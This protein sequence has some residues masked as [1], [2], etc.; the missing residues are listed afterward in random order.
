MQ[1]KLIHIILITLLVAS[2][3][4]S[5]PTVS[6]PAALYII[7]TNDIHTNID[8]AITYDQIAAL[9]KSLGSTGANVL[10]LDNGDY[11]QGTP[12]GSIDKGE[13]IIGIMEKCG[14]DAAGIGN[15]ETDFG[16]DI[17]KQRISD[18]SFPILSCNFWKLDSSGNKSELLGKPYQIFKFEDYSV[19]VVGISTPETIASGQKRYFFDENDKP[20]YSFSGDADGSEFYENIQE[21][22][23]AARSEGADYVIA[24]GHLGVA[25]ASAPWRSYDVIRNTNGIDAF[26]D[27]HSHSLVCETVS[28]K[29]GKQIPLS[30]TGCYLSHLGLIS[31]NSEGEFSAEI[32]DELSDSDASTKALCSQLI[33]KVDEAFGEVIAESEINF[34]IDDENGNRLVRKMTTNASRLSTDAFYYYVCEVSQIPADIAIYNSGGVRNNVDAGKW[35]Y[36]SCQNIL[37]F[38]NLLCVIS[39]SGQTIKDALEWGAQVCPDE[40]AGPLVQCAMMSYEV[41]TSI[42]STVQKDEYDQWAGAPTGE[43]RVRNIKIFNT[44]SGEYENLDPDKIYKV[45][46]VD[47]I[48]LNSGSG[49]TMWDK[50]PNFEV[51]LTDV[52]I[53]NM[54]LAEY[55]KAFED[56]DGNGLPN[57]ASSTSPLAKYS[58]YP[59]N[60]EITG[61]DGSRIKFVQ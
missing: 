30:Q 31:M 2:C 26:I 40:E 10:L 37:A 25:A 5:T 48:L 33:A 57:I 56:S 42:T 34:R 59:L 3:Q 28:N 58:S 16:I 54:A 6:N 22:V 46:G 12:Y 36:K 44:T 1:N 17:L 38:S 9:K 32:L 4:H 45:A 20:L 21:Y 55:I 51:V 19:A 14:Y 43:Y 41:N 11:I 24:L 50:D 7:H 8:K 52:G 23:D 60:Y 18:A 27:G 15:H 35:S 39:C 53:D 61:N 29:D 47:Y 13:S 49:M